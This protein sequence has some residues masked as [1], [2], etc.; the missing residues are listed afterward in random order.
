MWYNYR[1]PRPLKQGAY[2]YAA[3]NNVPI[4]SCFTEIIDKEKKLTM[5]FMQ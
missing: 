1:K 4:I 3:K 5:N 2:Y